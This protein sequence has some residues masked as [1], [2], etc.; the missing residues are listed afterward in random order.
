MKR[1]LINELKENEETKI[2]GFATKIR[3]TKY[4]I[5]VVLRDRTGFIQV[6]IDKATNDALVKE[7]EGVIAGSVI[8]FTGKMVLPTWTSSS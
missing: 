3:D 5:F 4:M 2:S 1:T 8:E 7:L 6:S